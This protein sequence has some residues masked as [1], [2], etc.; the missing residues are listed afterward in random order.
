[1]AALLE[2]ITLG[3]RSLPSKCEPRL[4]ASEHVSG[5]AYHGV[6]SRPAQALQ[7]SEAYELSQ[8]LREA[9]GDRENPEEHERPDHGHTTAAY[10]TQAGEESASH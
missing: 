3:K 6:Q 1:M 2:A 8:V 9:A 5:R 4:G 10:I 7:G